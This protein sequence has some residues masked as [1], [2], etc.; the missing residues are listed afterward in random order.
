MEKKMTNA[1]AVGFVLDTYADTLPEDVKAKL[2]AIKTSYENKSANRKPTKRQEENVTLK[3]EIFEI[4]PT[5]G[6]GVTVTEILATLGNPEITNP[7]V[8]AILTKANKDG[9]VVRTV[10]KKKAYF[11]K[12]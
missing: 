11:K 12:A 8:T 10:E 1:M 3:A 7:R 6:L 2:V 4:L 9:E 5:E